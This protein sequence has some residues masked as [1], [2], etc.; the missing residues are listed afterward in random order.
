QAADPA[1]TANDGAHDRAGIT[2]LSRFGSSHMLLHAAL[3]SSAKG[4]FQP[5]AECRRRGL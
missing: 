1:T 3:F 2:D 5:K 4:L